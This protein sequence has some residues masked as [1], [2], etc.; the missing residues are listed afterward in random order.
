MNK[1]YKNIINGFYIYI[2]YIN[3]MNNNKCNYSPDY[4]SGEIIIYML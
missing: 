3:N 4:I 1:S 2:I